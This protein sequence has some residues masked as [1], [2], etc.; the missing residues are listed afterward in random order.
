LPI[1]WKPLLSGPVAIVI[2]RGGILFSSSGAAPQKT[3]T[4]VT[5][6]AARRQFA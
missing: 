2:A 1:I 6:M 3:A 4:A 5:L